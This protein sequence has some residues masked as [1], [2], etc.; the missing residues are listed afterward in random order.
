MAQLDPDV[1]GYNMYIDKLDSPKA[2]PGQSFVWGDTSLVFHWEDSDTSRPGF[3]SPYL[4]TP[5]ENTPIYFINDSTLW[6]GDTTAHGGVDLFL[7]K[8]VYEFTV[9]AVDVAGNES[10]RSDPVYVRMIRRAKVP[11]NLLFKER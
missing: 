10:G 6:N 4:S 7:E 8:G 5:V 11:V 3:V 9:T 1:A 2:F